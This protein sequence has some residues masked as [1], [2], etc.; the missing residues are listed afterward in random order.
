MNKEIE[1]WL[2][3]FWE[4]D[5]SC[6]AYYDSSVDNLVPNVTF[7][8]KDRSVLED[9]RDL[10]GYGYIRTPNL[11]VR[12]WKRCMELLILFCEHIVGEQSVS[13]V[14]NMLEKCDLDT[15]ALRHEPS[16]PWIVGF[17]DAEGHIDWDNC[18]QLQSNFAQKDRVVLEDVQAHIGGSI[19]RDKSTYKGKPYYY[20]KLYPEGSVLRDFIPHILKYSRHE[21]KRRKLLTQIYALASDGNGVW[22]RWARELI[23]RE[24]SIPNSQVAKD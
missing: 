24:H 6:G 11:Q 22:N 4:G 15:L 18:G 12:G 2:T 16:M 14:N 21:S 1:Q 17:F 5:G 7:I 19:R 10:I 20:F 23:S 9:I 3:G 8:Q 13:K